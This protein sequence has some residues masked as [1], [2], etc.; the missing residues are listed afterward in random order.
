[1]EKVLDKLDKTNKQENVRNVWQKIIPVAGREKPDRGESAPRRESNVSL[2]FYLNNYSASSGDNI[3]NKHGAAH[4]IVL[5]VE[6]ADKHSRVV[7]HSHDVSKVLACKS[8]P[9]KENIIR[10]SFF[11]TLH[12]VL[13]SIFGP[14]AEPAS[15]PY[16]TAYTLSTGCGSDA[17]RRFKDMRIVHHKA[18]IENRNSTKYS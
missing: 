4:I 10:L 12:C 3:L 15:H 8:P 5:F 1:M 11:G 18:Q 9:R 13:V 6:L 14:Q 7:T 2:F 17:A 16:T